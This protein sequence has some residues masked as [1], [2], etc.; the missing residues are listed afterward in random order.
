MNSTIKLRSR[1][2]NIFPTAQKREKREQLLQETVKNESWEEKTWETGLWR[3]D[4][5]VSLRKR[6]NMQLCFMYQYCWH[7]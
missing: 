2:L 7:C 6:N 5:S 1:D 3:S 4:V